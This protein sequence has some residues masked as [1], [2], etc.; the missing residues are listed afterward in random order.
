MVNCK[1]I[2]SNI[3]F[4]RND[5]EIKKKKMGALYIGVLITIATILV[6]VRGS[7]P[8]QVRCIFTSNNE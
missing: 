7:N 4:V 1:L 8:F 6:A 2:V 3:L 5:F